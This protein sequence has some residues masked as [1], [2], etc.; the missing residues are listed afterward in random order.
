MGALQVNLDSPLPAEV[1]IGDGTAL[2]LAGTCFDEQR[3]ITG[4][5]F[6]LDGRPQP[7]MAHGMPR[8]DYFRALH[9]MLDP[10][11]RVAADPDSQE[12]P[13]LHSY[14]S[15]F[16]GL[17]RI[18]PSEPGRE[19]ELELRAALSDGTEETVPL[20]RMAVSDLLEPAEVH[21]SEAPGPQVAICLATYNPPRELLRRQVESIRAQSHQ[22]WVCLISD[23]CSRPEDFQA[24]QEIVGD[25]PRF[26][27]SRS[28]RRL[29]F[30]LNFER[31]LTL[32]PRQAPFIALSDQ[33][34]AWY[35]HKLETLLEAIGERQ[36]AYSDAR[37]VDPQGG[38]IAPTYWGARSNNHRDLHALLM[39][40]SVTGAAS[41][42]RRRVLE[43]ALPFP[44]GQFAHFHDHWI[45]LVALVLGGIE[46]VPEPLYD[47]VQH[48]Q[49]ALGHAQA[50]QVFS[51]RQR[52]GR[53]RV[54]PRERIRAYR[55]RY[56]V[57]LMRLM[58]FATILDMRCGA[59]MAPAERRR[60]HEFLALERSWPALARL[61]VQAARE[62]TGRP[63]TLGAEWAL[64]QSLLWRRLLAVSATERPRRRLRLDA[65]PPPDL[66][67]RPAQREAPDA[68]G[69]R[70]LW[71]KVAPLELAAS[72]RA[73]RRLNILIPT[74]DLRHFFGGYIAKLNLARALAR[75][76]HQVRLVTV[77][78]VAP[79]PPSWRSQVE[80]YSGLGGLFEDVEVAFG[81]E[82]G[83]LEVSRGDGFV[84]STWWT[85]HLAHAAR[86]EL[87]EAG[88]A[89]LIQEYEPMTFP[90]G[91]FAALAAQSYRFPHFGLFSSELLR[92]YFRRHEIGVYAGG[93]TPGDELSAAFQ[94]AITPIPGPG[95]EQLSARR[96]R[97]VLFYARPEPHAARN[98]FELGLLAL[99]RAAAEGIFREGWELRGIGSVKGRRRIR[100]GAGLELELLPRASQT[101][102]AGLLAEH[103][104]G[105]ALMYTPHPSLVPIEMACAG[106]LTVTNTFENKTAAA[107]RE[108]STNLIAGEP[109]VEGIVSA[110]GQA[111]AGVR[112]A[113]RRVRGSA[114]NWSRDWEQSFPAGLLERI[115]RYLA[116]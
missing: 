59:E 51:L 21:V 3:Q 63:E 20:G 90:M 70:V 32:A 24:I 18:A 76:G 86:T 31:A 47:Y 97:R 113:E 80:A 107:L 39:A 26:V 10:Y 19:L 38:L 5:E 45:A 35:P 48:G 116:P 110:L 44:P 106:L 46:F 93:G 40:N 30:Y 64:F 79:L 114:V 52:L 16:W 101:D 53:I 29:G 36:L 111:A 83:P 105:L 71:E 98:M 115:E 57:D 9:P 85:A 87:Q 55:S 62:L 108:I 1:S 103:D 17:V 56:F 14:R 66:A 82:G 60:L 4:L 78:P 109:S 72:D 100:L 25:D 15:G 92:D 7:V 81:R 42:F 94:N 91:S 69:A 12:D 95:A 75:R 13:R 49:A 43:H 112:D 84:A 77:D 54:D 74:F 11:Q 41:L 58:S 102:Y 6:V 2:F 23:D 8:L 88:F 33:D 50:N 96:T 27:L 22:N 65:V 37:I 68:G 89:Y 99:Q 73:P 67:P 28:P 34:D 61:G 104:V